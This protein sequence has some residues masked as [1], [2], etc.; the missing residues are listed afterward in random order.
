V[1]RVRQAGRPA[2]CAVVFPTLR[3]GGYTVWSDAV[4]RAGTAIIRAGHVTEFWL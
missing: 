3:A 4:T 2:A 1:V